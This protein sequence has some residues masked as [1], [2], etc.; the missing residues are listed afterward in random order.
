MKK[1][2]VI[3]IIVSFLVGIITDFLP[4]EFPVEPLVGLAFG[5]FLLGILAIIL[6]KNCLK[7]KIPKKCICND[8]SDQVPGGR[9]QGK[10]S[11]GYSFGLPEIKD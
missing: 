8:I 11:R 2:G 3:L 10:H 5:Y 9:C 7:D 4:K 6:D 1:I